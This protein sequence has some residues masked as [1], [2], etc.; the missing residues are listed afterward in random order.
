MRT[1][2][3]AKAAM[4]LLFGGAA[5]FLS[6][7]NWYF[8]QDTQKALRQQSQDFKNLQT[9][10]QEQAKA[11][12]DVVVAESLHAK[13]E[14][15][16]QAA[17]AVR[18]LL[19]SMIPPE[20]R[21]L[22]DPKVFGIQSKR[23]SEEFADVGIFQYQPDGQS[24]PFAVL[25]YPEGFGD[26]LDNLDWRMMRGWLDPSAEIVNADGGA[27]SREALFALSGKLVAARGTF[28]RKDGEGTAVFRY[29][30]LELRQLSH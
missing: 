4:Y 6:V 20:W 17:D 12:A 10:V 1:V 8:H 25:P 27:L 18:A 16:A 11:R 24:H 23:Q 26:E 7:L 29:S 13:D 15:K 19:V 2:M 28:R 30:R 21:G 3:V 14:A 22:N 9:L 5:I